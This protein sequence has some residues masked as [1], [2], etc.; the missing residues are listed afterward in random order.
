MKPIYV[1]IKIYI[2]E[3]IIYIYIYIS[4]RN[5]MFWLI[6]ANN[7]SGHMCE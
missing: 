1:Y 6:Q 5:P 3:F 7:V 2:K 4:V